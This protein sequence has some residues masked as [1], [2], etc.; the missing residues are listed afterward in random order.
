MISGL[1]D[2]DIAFH[3]SPPAFPTLNE[4][5]YKLVRELFT[6]NIYDRGC[7]ETI[8]NSQQKIDAT[9]HS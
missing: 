2:S 4:Y 9:A 3:F 6:E 1:T 5:K 7:I 8:M